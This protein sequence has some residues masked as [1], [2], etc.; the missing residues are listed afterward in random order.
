ME[1]ETEIGITYRELVVCPRRSRGRIVNILNGAKTE[2][3]R[4]NI[5]GTMIDS[6]IAPFEYYKPWMVNMGFSSRGWRGSRFVCE[7]HSELMLIWK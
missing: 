4:K 1:N 2:I 5:I 6:L 7:M 3:E